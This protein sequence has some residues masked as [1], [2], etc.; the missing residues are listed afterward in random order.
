V[1]LRT[2]VEPRPVAF[3][4]YDGFVFGGKELVE[5][6]ETGDDDG[7]AFGWYL[8]Q[9]GA[10]RDREGNDAAAPVA[11][12][13]LTLDDAGAAQVTIDRPAGAG[14]RSLL[15]ELEY[16]DANGERL[17]SST[18]V[19]LWPAAIA[20][21]IKLEGWAGTRDKLRFQVVALNLD[22]QPVAGRNV[23]VRLFQRERSA[24]RKR[25]IGGFY[26]YES[27]SR[28]KAID[29]HCA[30][31]T[32]RHGLLSC[33]IAPGASGE[34]LLGARTTDAHGNPA[35]AST[36]AWVFGNDDWWFNPG[37][38]DRMDV[39]PEK[40]EYA[41]GDVARFQVRS[42]FR[43]ATALV[44]VM[45]EGVLRSFVTEIDGHEPVIEV[46]ITAADAPNV[47]VSVLA[48][49]GRVSWWRAALGS[50]ARYLHLPWAVD[51][52]L[53]TALVDLGKPAYRYG[54]GRIAVDWRP[55]R[56]DVDVKPAREVYP[57][58][59][60]AQVDVTVRAAN[61][62][63]LPPGAEVALAAVDEG[64]LDLS[65]NDTWDLLRA[66]MGERGLE[67]WTSTAQM[68][69]VGKRHFGRKAVP[70]GGGGGRGPAARERFDSLLLWQDRVT[71]DADGRARVAVPLNDSLS[72]FRI[73]AVA[74]AG[75]DRFGSGAATIRTAQDLMLLPGVAPLVREGD[76]YTAVFTL[77]NASSRAMRVAANA[78]LTAVGTE[79][80][81]GQPPA[82][83]VTLAPGAAHDIAWPVSAPAGATAIGWDVRA[84]EQAAEQTSGK[85]DH[86]TDHL[87]IQQ[88]VIPV[89]P[90][91]VQ[92]ATI[93]QIAGSFSLPAAAPRGALPGRGGIEVALRAHLGDGLDGVREYMSFYSYICLEQTL[94]RAVALRDAALW[95]SV[96]ERLPAYLD[97]DGLARYFPSDWLPGS[98]TLTSYVLTVAHEAG[99]A[100]P[101]ATRE[102]ML[103]ALT[104]F[105]NGEITRDSVLPTTDLALRKTAAIAALAR[106]GKASASMLSSFNIE[107]A[108]WPTSG[109]LDL[110][111]VTRHLSPLPPGV[112]PRA[113][114]E[115]LLRARLDASGTTLRFATERNDA[116]WWLMISGDVNAARAVL[117][118]LDSPDW[119]AD[120]PRLVRGLLG[121]LEHGHW[122]TT[123][124]NAWGVLA[125]E[126]FSAAFEATPVSGDTQVSYGD[127]TRSV[128]WQADQVP[129][130]VELPWVEGTAPLHATHQGSGKPWAIVASRAAVPRSEPVEAG[131]HIERTVTPVVQKTPGAWHTGNVARVTLTVHAQSDAGWVV[132]DDPIPAGA[133]VLG[134]GLSRDSSLLTQGEKRTGWV[135]PAYEERRFDAFRAYYSFVPAGQWTVEYTLRLN[136]VGDFNLPPT[137]VEAMYAPEVNAE[138][139][140]DPVRVNAP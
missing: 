24:Y 14:P 13:E 27:S 55:H 34:L 5:G 98:D 33:Q 76:S 57:V 110:L 122:N 45:R 48:V 37:D 16:Q 26:T 81:I 25:L 91:R 44:S 31:E 104:R 21:G 49:R 132:V 140:L 71:L 3:K 62:S 102:R 87:A 64:L 103:N 54:I 75:A 131:F 106:Y 17:A 115:R 67:V 129:A 69:V 41:S 52:A 50:A 119:R 108:L 11:V 72:A 38:A 12:R 121:R 47:Y 6:P 138:L 94:S 15:A 53:P 83:T 101:D 100:I 133:S 18:R 107:P 40:K 60:T 32:D 35:I 127:A 2:Q 7:D 74:H 68:Q 95:Q 1:T 137:R 120:M 118:V 39:L 123:V 30:G 77:R 56:L 8:R 9:F 73:V 96:M 65:P 36:T 125:M 80:P 42:P 114:L 79:A 58:R 28:L 126:K 10:Y 93:E 78:T 51:G 82:Q 22:G 99:W 66:M 135:H 117:E 128:A 90:V 113:D 136:T 139:P 46:P 29:A 124:A 88:A 116:L 112:P 97:R 63:A 86:A 4:H 89:W 59:D 105:V 84:S 23:E 134:S 61:G 19:P 43:H 70:H 130:P 109:L 20:L 111:D 92:Q 85:D